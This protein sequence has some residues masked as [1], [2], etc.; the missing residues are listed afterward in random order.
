M[1][2]RLKDPIAICISKIR[3]LCQKSAVSPNGQLW[4]IFGCTTSRVKCAV[5]VIRI[6]GPDSLKAITA[7][8]SF[9]IGSVKSRYAYVTQLRHVNDRGLI[10][11]EVLFLVFR[12][13]KSYTGEDVVE[14]HCHGGKVSGIIL[15][16]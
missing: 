6:S 14:L 7:M 11:D 16:E 5:S 13:P 3:H 10:L 12:A 1:L 8:T 2:Q 9:D 4:T 15:N